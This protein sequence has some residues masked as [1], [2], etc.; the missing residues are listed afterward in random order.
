[1]EI[2]KILVANHSEIS[3]RVFRDCNELNIST[4]YVYTYENRYSQHSYKADESYQI[5]EDNQPLKPYSDMDEIVHL[6]K[7]KNVD[8]IHPGY[9]FLSENSTFARKCADNHIIFI[10]PDPKAMDSLGD[11]ITAKKLR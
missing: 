3:I 1:M 10:G 5:D 9:G 7:A 11:K 4:L 2:K 8:A 6:A